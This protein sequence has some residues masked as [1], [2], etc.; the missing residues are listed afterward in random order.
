MTAE[1]RGN[2]P[3][4]KN[5]SNINNLIKRSALTNR[6]KSLNI[7]NNNLVQKNRNSYI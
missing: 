6:E 4:M 5:Q 2:Y 1:M 7:M 3:V